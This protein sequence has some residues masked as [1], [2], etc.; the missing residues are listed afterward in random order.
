MFDESV[1]LLL[2]A[3]WFVP[4]SLPADNQESNDEDFCPYHM[5]E[6]YDE[7]DDDDHDVEDYYAASRSSTLLL[8]NR[9]WGENGYVRAGRKEARPISAQEGSSSSSSGF[10]GKAAVVSKGEASGI[11]AGRRARRAAK[12]E[13]ADKAAAAKHLQ[14][15]ERLGRV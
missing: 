15:L 9:R 5:D 13:A 7:E 14:H 4:L 11:A 1:C 10:K 6:A 8:R 2:R 3:Q 12:R